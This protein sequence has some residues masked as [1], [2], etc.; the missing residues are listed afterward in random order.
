MTEQ[1]EPTSA[2]Y[3]PDWQRIVNGLSAD[4][5]E[6]REAH[7]AWRRHAEAARADIALRPDFVQHASTDAIRAQ[8]ERA[9]AQADLWSD[10]ARSLFLLLGEREDRPGAPQRLLP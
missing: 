6:E 4:L 2:T 1:T 7:R 8:Y 3:T 9:Q 5:E 10:R